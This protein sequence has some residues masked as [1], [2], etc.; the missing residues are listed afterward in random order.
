MRIVFDGEQLGFPVLDPFGGGGGLA[1]GAVSVAAG[2]VGDLAVAAA[3]AL[4]DV[5]AE[6]GGA[7]G[8]DVAEDATPLGGERAAVA[9]EEG[10]PMGPEDVGDFEAWS[11][12][13]RASPAG[14]SIRSSGLR[15][16]ST[17]A[18]ETWV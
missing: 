15:V 8:G 17:A 16:A 5:S 11:V 2:V 1:L 18:G 12:H 10:V 4:L 13:G 7:A 3:V 14:G 6:G 9:V